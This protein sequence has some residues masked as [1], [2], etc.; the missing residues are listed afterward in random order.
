MK[1]LNMEN[2]FICTRG[3]TDRKSLGDKVIFSGYYEVNHIKI[4][5]HLKYTLKQ[6]HIEILWIGRWD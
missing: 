4:S 5:F 2:E 1:K 3:Y 6:G